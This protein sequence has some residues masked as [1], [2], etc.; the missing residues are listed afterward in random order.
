MRSGGRQNRHLVL[1]HGLCN[2]NVHLVCHDVVLW[3]CEE[4]G[5]ERL[6]VECEG[7]VDYGW[8]MAIILSEGIIQHWAHRAT[9]CPGIHRRKIYVLS[10]K[11]KELAAVTL[12][13]IV[14]MADCALQ[15]EVLNVFWTN[16]RELS[17]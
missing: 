3:R 5:G 6:K 7:S 16:A 14:M 10:R 4:A 13:C 15:R 9:Y 2:C 1:D 11:I 8:Q 12:S 17:R